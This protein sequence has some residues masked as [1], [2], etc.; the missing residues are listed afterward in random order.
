MNPE[1]EQNLMQKIQDYLSD[2]E[3]RVWL[4]D[5]AGYFKGMNGIEI[6]EILEDIEKKFNQWINRN[7][8][9]E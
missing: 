2:T 6:S 3:A 7:I 8:F 5:N 4:Q 9:E 1:N